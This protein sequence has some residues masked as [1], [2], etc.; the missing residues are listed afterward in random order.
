MTPPP[1][2]TVSALPAEPSEAGREALAAAAVSAKVSWRTILT[3]NLPTPGVGYMFFLVNIF[4]MKFST[5]VLLI[6]PAAMGIIFGVARIWDAIS[7]PLAGYL[8]DRTR[9]R[10]GRRRP[11]FLAS[12]VP[13]GGFFLMMWS[14]PA[15]FSDQWLVAWMAIAVFGFYTGT[16]ILIVPHASLGAELTP[17]YHDRTR[18][19]AARQVGWNLGAFLSLGAMFL[20][21]GAAEPRGTAVWLAALAAVVTAA[22]IVYATAHLH[23]RPEFLGRGGKNAYSAFADVWRNPHARLLLL[24]FLIESVG[25]ATIGIL[26]LYVA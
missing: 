6:A 23:E 12:A 1:P 10:L 2:V 4:L 21:I 16:T 14:P 9:T 20:L 17:N 18:V 25:G 13:I 26:T 11:W 7:D 3:Y 15:T 8:S 22:L 5:D 19:F 24:V